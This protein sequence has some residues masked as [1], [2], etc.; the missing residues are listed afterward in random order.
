M[1]LVAKSDTSSGNTTC[2]SFVIQSK[3][4]KFV[5]TAPQTVPSLRLNGKCP[6]PGYDPE[7]AFDFIK[8]HG[9]AVRAIGA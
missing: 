7:Q 2:T 1:T 9:L 5:I 3:D 8:E 6:L 4:L